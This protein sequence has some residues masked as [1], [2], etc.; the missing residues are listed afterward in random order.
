MKE[1]KR[2]RIFFGT[3]ASWL[4]SSFI[5]CVFRKEI[6]LKYLTLRQKTINLYTIKKIGVPESIYRAE[7]EIKADEIT[8]YLQAKTNILKRFK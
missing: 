6:E 8:P 1:F 3:Q 7:R 2:A 4:H 5:F